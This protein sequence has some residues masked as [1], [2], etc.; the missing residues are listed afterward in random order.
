MRWR[1]RRPLYAEQ[2]PTLWRWLLPIFGAM[3]LGA[4]GVLTIML[5]RKPIIEDV[6]REAIAD[7]GFPEADLKVV[8]IDLKAAEISG[9]RLTP[10][11]GAERVRARFRLWPLGN[12]I[13]ES[14]EVIGLSLDLRDPRLADALADMMS[15]EATDEPRP[16]LP[17]IALN[18]TRVRYGTPLGPAEATLDAAVRRQRRGDTQV[19]AELATRLAEEPARASLTMRLPFER[20]KPV[21][22]RLVAGWGQASE[23]VWRLASDF[24]IGPEREPAIARLSTL[25]L[26]LPGHG[27][28]TA[29]TVELQ[30]AGL[31]QDQQ[32]LLLHVPALLHREAMP[33][34]GPLTLNAALTLA[35]DQLRLEGDATTLGEARL[36]LSGQHDLGRKA[37]RAI[38][39]LGG[40]AFSSPGCT[41]FDLS[42]RFGANLTADGGL[43]A[44]GDVSWNQGALQARAT[45]SARSLSLRGRDWSLNGVDGTV[46]LGWSGDSVVTPGRQSLAR[47]IHERP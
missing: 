3:A 17:T 12:P 40:L 33:W 21:E 5:W 4:V 23:A 38:W 46:A 30:L 31:G 22:G 47:F 1:R 25:G 27:E 26:L 41:L 11:I 16:P 10:G 14:I 15:H 19:T 45:I 35:G 36:T 6:L 32:V 29:E 13:A 18:R 37:G 9:L 20:G 2:R 42:P 39:R 24:A 44:D 34:H 7:L 43:E 28:L 8:S